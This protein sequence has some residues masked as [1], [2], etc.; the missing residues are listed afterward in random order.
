MIKGVP[1]KDAFLL[2][3]IHVDHKESELTGMKK[4]SEKSAPGKPET[5]K[6]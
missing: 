6:V 3:T 2:K 5:P 1:D 4:V